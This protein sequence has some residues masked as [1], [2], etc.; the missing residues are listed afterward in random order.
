MQPKLTKPVNSNPIVINVIAEVH[1]DS[2]NKKRTLNTK[3]SAAL[4]TSN[5]ENMDLNR[6]SRDDKSMLSPDDIVQM[7]EESEPDIELDSLATIS[8]KDLVPITLDDQAISEILYLDNIAEKN[9]IPSVENEKMLEKTVKPI[10]LQEDIVAEPIPKK[11]K[12][13][14][15]DIITLTKKPIFSERKTEKKCLKSIKTI[16]KRTLQCNKCKMLYPFN[17]SY[18]KCTKCLKYYCSQCSNNSTSEYLCDFCLS[19]D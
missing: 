14:V 15:L 17:A 6:Y 2:R 19:I 3:N 8:T 12:V 10:P 16:I 18:N 9:I 11:R 5:K 1:D 7:C 13:Q 4:L